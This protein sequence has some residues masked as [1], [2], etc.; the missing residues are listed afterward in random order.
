MKAARSAERKINRAAAST[1]KIQA[2][3]ILAEYL[4]E[5]YLP[6]FSNYRKSLV[7]ADL[8]APGM[9]ILSGTAYCWGGL[10]CL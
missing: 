7:S 8:P 5:S 9:V 1:H 3:D 4:M 2:Q 10:L 6:A